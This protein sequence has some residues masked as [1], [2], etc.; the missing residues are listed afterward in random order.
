MSSLSKIKGYLLRLGLSEKES[1]AY[2]YLQS[3][4]PQLVSSLAQACNLTRTHAYDIVRQLEKAGF[5]HARGSSYGKK[6]EALPLTESGEILEQKAREIS[7]LKNELAVI[8]PLAAALERQPFSEKTQVAYFS[9]LENVRKLL[10]RSLQAKELVLRLAGSEFDMVNA[11]GEEFLINYHQ[12]R[13]AKGFELLA[14][15]PGIKRSAQE[16]FINDRL[17]KRQVRLRPEGEIRLKSNILLWDSSV[18]LLSLK[19]EIYGT[20]IESADLALMM[21][22]WFDF[23]WK[24]SKRI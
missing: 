5:C 11:L 15:R 24:Q 12:R 23:I 21:K 1:L 9:G 10:N 7:G 18:V 6:I 19:D 22:S 4:G 3:H 14:L 8:A 17:Y 13:A 16:I 20:L 2:L